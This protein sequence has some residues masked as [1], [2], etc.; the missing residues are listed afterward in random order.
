MEKSSRGAGFFD[1]HTDNCS[2]QDENVAPFFTLFGLRE[3]KDA[4]DT[5]VVLRD[6]IIKKLSPEEQALI[7]KPIYHFIGGGAVAPKEGG[8]ARQVIR[9][10]LSERGG[11]PF[12]TCNL[13]EAKMRVVPYE[14][15]EALFDHKPANHQAAVDFVKKL[16]RITEDHPDLCTQVRLAPGVMLLV[17]NHAVLH[18]RANTSR[19]TVPDTYGRWVQRTYMRPG[20]YKENREFT[21]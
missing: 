9:P 20:E 17:D 8:G 11:K 1:M 4:I 14:G 5:T 2:M 3:G 18:G 13:A 10:I 12:F 6:E 7:R 19:D 15:N 21:V 16:Q